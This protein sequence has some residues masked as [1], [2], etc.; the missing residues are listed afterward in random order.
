MRHQRAENLSGKK[1]LPVV[2][3]VEDDEGLNRIIQ[4]AVQR[5]GFKTDRAATGSEVIQK[6]RNH[7]D[8]I[9]LL[10]YMLPYTTGKQ[11]IRQLKKEGCLVPFVIMTGH[12]D[13]RVAVEMMKLGARDYVVKDKDFI[14]LLPEVVKKLSAELQ[15]D[16]ALANTREALAKREKALAAVYKI[17]TNTGKSYQE[18]CEYCS[19]KLADIL[20]LSSVVTFIVQKKKIVSLARFAGGK[21]HTLGNITFPCA[22]CAKIMNNQKTV[23][24][25][26]DLSG[27]LSDC[28]C[29]S[30]DYHMFAGVPIKNEQ[31]AQ[32]MICVFDAKKR[33]LSTDELQLIDLF[34]HYLSHEIDQKN[35]EEE[36]RHGREMKILGQLTSGV[37]HEVRNPLNAINAMVE[38]MYE[39]FKQSDEMEP[40]KF[41]ISSQVERLSRLMQD[42]LELGK[43]I[44][45][46]NVIKMPIEKLCRA[47][48]DLWKKTTRKNHDI[49]FEDTDGTAKREI[50]VDERK[51]QQVLI[52]LLE[53]ASHHSPEDSRI[54]LKTSRVDGNNVAIKVVD[55]GKG[56]AP[57][58]MGNLFEPFFTTRRQGTGLG[59]SIVRHIV[60]THGGTI[61]AYN[62]SHRPGSTFEIILPLNTMENGNTERGQKQ[63]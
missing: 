12:G 10:D 3:I 32:G 45:Q 51:V 47:T 31:S 27:K 49:C 60:N 36:I 33:A 22:T 55:Q 17:A 39:D 48:I 54:R 44:D 1:H 11:I 56:I 14:A 34:A 18:L 37:A 42:L 23:Q 58:H 50:L 59:L 57:E 26:G 2:L 19:R 20:S 7:P 29:Y 41:H 28:F 46:D 9:L 38:A 53:N 4:K 25:T 24:L 5:Q 35:M 21:M 43:P 61:Y 6:V 40:Y 62:N 30:S 15:K 8:T 16:L 63:S 52:N 13:E